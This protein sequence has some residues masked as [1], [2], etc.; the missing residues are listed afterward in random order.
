MYQLPELTSSV[1]YYLRKFACLNLAIYEA[2]SDDTT[3]CF[4]SQR[5]GARG[6][7]EVFSC[8][9]KFV[10]DKFDVLEPQQ[11]RTLVIWSDRCVGQNNNYL[12]ILG[13][14]YL[15]ATGYFTKVKLVE[16]RCF[17]F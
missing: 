1:N 4:W 8:M 9:L 2:T 12:N 14:R 5:D 13:Y 17:R 6:S 7:E 11:E 10:H 15:V 3:M 16:T